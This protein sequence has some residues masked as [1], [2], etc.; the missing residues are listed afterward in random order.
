MASLHH[1]YKQLGCSAEPFH[2]YGYSNFLGLIKHHHNH[3]QQCYLKNLKARTKDHLELWRTKKAS[4]GQVLGHLVVGAGDECC[5][6][7]ARRVRL[8]CHGKR[9]QSHRPQ[10]L[11]HQQAQRYCLGTAPER[12]CQLW[13]YKMYGLTESF[14][15]GYITLLLL[16]INKFNNRNIKVHLVL[17]I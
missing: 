5:G 8:G 11:V 2:F 9:P 3:T 6:V 12:N 10:D 1:F 7:H 15:T 14:P 13:L 17:R 16:L 4:P